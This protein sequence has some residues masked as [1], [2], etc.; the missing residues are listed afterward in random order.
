MNLRD[1]AI[2]GA[3]ADS[4]DEPVFTR[5]V[6]EFERLAVDVETY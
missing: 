2:I 3:T 1:D 5:N 4:V 6:K